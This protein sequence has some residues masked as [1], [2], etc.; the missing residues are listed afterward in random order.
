MGLSLGSNFSNTL[1]HVY[2]WALPSWA[3]SV[4][5][6]AVLSHREGGSTQTNENVTPM[7]VCSPLVTIWEWS[8]T[9]V[10]SILAERQ[11][12]I[13]NWKRNRLWRLPQKLV[14]EITLT[15][16]TVCICWRSQRTKTIL[17]IANVS[18]KNIKQVFCLF[19]W[20]FFYNILSSSLSELT[21]A[22]GQMN[23]S[24]FLS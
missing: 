18:R 20:L 5:M 10:Q 24:L 13:S 16:T 4:S 6:K 7:Q 8:F 3:I 22:H 2:I 19:L 11:W 17:L 1:S 23:Q 15:T 12:I 21:D 14:N 9:R